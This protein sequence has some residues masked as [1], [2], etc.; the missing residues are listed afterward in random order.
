MAGPGDVPSLVFHLAIPTHDLD[1]AQRFYTSVLGAERARRYEDRVTFRFFGHQ[2]VCHLAPAG[3]DPAPRP[4]PRHFG[5]TFA[6]LE[7]FDALHRRILLTGTRLCEERAVRW[8]ERRERHETFFLAD[9]SNN[10][11]E[12]KCYADPGCMY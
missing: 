5:I 6:R 9:P 12:F 10:V 1:A 2:V 3:V 7:D 4:Y 11:L 8:P